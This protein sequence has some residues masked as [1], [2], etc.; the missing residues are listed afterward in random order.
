MTE[1]QSTDIVMTLCISFFLC[2]LLF[3]T[4]SVFI[5]ILLFSVI[6]LFHNNLFKIAHADYRIQ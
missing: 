3:I 4:V 5:Y 6:Y 1:N 2:L